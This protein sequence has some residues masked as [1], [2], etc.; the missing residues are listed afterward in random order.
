[1]PLWF[2][3]QHAWQLPWSS[4]S[5][6]SSPLGS[7]YIK[8]H[9]VNNPI[10]PILSPIGTFNYNL[11]KFFVP[12]I[13]P[14]TMN[15]SILNNS[16]NSYD[17]VREHKNVD[18]SNKVMASYDVQSLFTNNTLMKLLKLSLTDCS[19]SPEYMNFPREQFKE[20]LEIAIKECPFIS[21]NKLNIQTDGV[22]AGSCLSPSFTKALLCFPEDKWI[23]DCPDALTPAHYM[24]MTLS[25][26]SVLQTMSLFF[27]ITVILNTKI[28]TLINN[29]LSFLD[30]LITL[31]NGKAVTSV[32]RKPTFTGLGTHFLSFIPR[33]FKINAIKTLIHRC[34]HLSS[35]CS[36]FDTEIKFL[37]DFFKIS[38]SLDLVQKCISKFLDKT[39]NPEH[40]C[41][42]VL[43]KHYIKLLYYRDLSFGIRK[44]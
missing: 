8:F 24:L 23:S 30:V 5:F 27:L 33:V 2:S 13:E 26:C 39:L 10:C 43:E 11:A 7:P 21:N 3:G 36:I 38:H 44:N 28:L 15:N 41:D 37:M 35:N 1:M 40:Q 32:Y 6:S 22:A 14:L 31:E 25:Y 4:P 12:V 20:L 16:N 29:S 42:G 34:Y 9:K 18:V 17:F 19:D